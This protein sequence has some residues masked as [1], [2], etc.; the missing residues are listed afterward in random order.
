MH[1]ATPCLCNQGTIFSEHEVA[2]SIE[3]CSYFLPFRNFLKTVKIM[4]K[5]FL[6]TVIKF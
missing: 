4:K 6:I 2:I 3:D 1:A 5:I